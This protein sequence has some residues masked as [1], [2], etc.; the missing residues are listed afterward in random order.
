MLTSQILEYRRWRNL[1]NLLVQFHHCIEEET[2]AWEARGGMGLVK[3]PA[4]SGLLQ[5]HGLKAGWHLQSDQNVHW[6]MAAVR[7]F[8]SN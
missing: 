4:G 5:K 7:L 1:T 6:W 8:V 3:T 2:T